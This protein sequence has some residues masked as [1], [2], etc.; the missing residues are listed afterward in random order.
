MY[1]N[2]IL[3]NNIGDIRKKLF[4][5]LLCIMAASVAMYIF[6]L[7]SIIMTAIDYKHI[8]VSINN[9]E[10]STVNIEREYAG[11]LGQIEEG[12]LYTLGYQ[13][14]NSSFVVRID[15]DA[16]FSLLYGQ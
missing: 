15:P 16:N 10:K 4:S 12:K 7:L 8:I 1:N 6:T 3:N 9:L 2:K 5:S 11:K 13:K 14:V